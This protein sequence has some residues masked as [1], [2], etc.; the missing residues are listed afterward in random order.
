M[1]SASI[2][3]AD[4]AHLADQVKL[5]EVYAEA[6]HI[7]VMDAHFV[8]P[9]TIGP[10]VVAS[11]RPVTDRVFHGHLMVEAPESLFD[12][13]AEAGLDIVSFHHRGGRGPD[14]GHRQGSGSRYAGGDDA[15]H[16]D[17]GRRDLPVP[18][19]TRRRDAHEHQAGLVGTGVESR[20]IPA[21][22]GGAERGRS[23][24]PVHGR[25]ARRRGQDRQ[26]A[27]SDRCGSHRAG[28]RVGDLPGARPDR[29][30]PRARR[31][32]A[33]RGGA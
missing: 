18:G 12:D 26:C 3:S 21:A 29:G 17:A 10:V 27:T 16:G 11:L 33:R 8:P 7:D 1:L 9:L 31:H 20:R 6:I 28:C 19:R 13:L 24:R 22:R 4:F 14:A 25:G 2:L 23:S 5:V 32:R 30:R 15:Q